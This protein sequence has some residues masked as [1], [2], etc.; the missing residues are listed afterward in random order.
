MPSRKQFLEQ[1]AL[2]F[3]SFLHLPNLGSSM[4]KSEDFK[5][6]VV[7]DEEGEAY[8]W[9]D[10]TALVK[11]KISKIDNSQSIS[12]LSESFIPGDAIRVHK[13]SNEDELI[14]IHK[15]TGVFTLD[16]KEYA[17]QA[18]AVALVPKG[19][20]HG[21]RNTGAENIEMRFAYTPSGFEGYFRDLG[22]PLG[23]PF[24]QRSPEERKTIELKWGLIRKSN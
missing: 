1:S 21:L 2:G 19:I 5:G 17:V 13:H 12:F 4:I 16:E 24:R 23:Q 6:M 18:G 22:T 10:G 11:I 14:F 3:F 20:W 7:N 15:G 8:Q 9:R